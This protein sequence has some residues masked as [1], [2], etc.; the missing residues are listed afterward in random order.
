MN[1]IRIKEL[2]NKYS[3][4]KRAVY[5]LLA[6]RFF[7][8]YINVYR[9]KNFKLALFDLLTDYGYSHYECKITTHYYNVNPLVTVPLL[10]LLQTYQFVEDYWQRNLDQTDQFYFDFCSVFKDFKRYLRYDVSDKIHS[11]ACKR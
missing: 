7:I 9:D 4:S 6:I 2:K 3:S 10:T 5:F 11:E 8:Q 1:A